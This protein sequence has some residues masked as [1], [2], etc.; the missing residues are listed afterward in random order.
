MLKK[1]IWLPILIVLLAVIGCGLF[2]ARQVSKQ[3]P[4]KVYKAVEVEEPETPKPP[5]PGETAESGHWH[6][7]EWH[8]DPHETHEVPNG[9]ISQPIQTAASRN[10]TPAVVEIPEG[11]TDPEVIA[12]WQRVDYIANNIW[13]WGGVPNAETP[14]LIARLMPPPAGFSGPTGHSDG[15]ET[16]NLLFS[17]DS[18]DPRSAVVVATYLCEGIFGGWSI[19]D[20]LVEIGGP[21]VPYLIPYMLDMERMPAL[22]SYAIIVLGRIGERHREDLDGIVDHILIPRLEA[23]LA[24]EK[25]DYFEGKAAREYLPRLK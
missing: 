24:Q 16:A 19:I 10:Y 15:E 11:I 2:Y 17:L 20:M 14:A 23:I 25:P 7:D 8:A 4:V 12:A 9:D 5:P 22:R 6:G 13:E 21:A 3:A 1:K 18:N